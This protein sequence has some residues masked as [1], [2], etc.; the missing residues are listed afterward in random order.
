MADL[1]SREAAMNI[2]HECGG[3]EIYPPNMIEMR[4]KMLKLP[5]VDA[6]EVATL[7]SW[8]YKIAMNNIGAPVADM[9]E[10]CEEIIS[11]LS[12]LRRFAEERRENNG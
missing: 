3:D 12:G 5:A 10:A 1:I 2:L 7:E 4:G 9:A 8:L 6:V 11:R